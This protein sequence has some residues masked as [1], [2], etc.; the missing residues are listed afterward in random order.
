MKN[1]CGNIP[2]VRKSQDMDSIPVLVEQ[3]V[4][5]MDD[6]RRNS[7]L[8]GV[9]LEKIRERQSFRAELYVILDNT[10]KGP[11]QEPDPQALLLPD[12]MNQPNKD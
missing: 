5:V 3:L 10:E 2:L 4:E 1:S 11:G 7:L 6:M 12:Q 9:I 8:A